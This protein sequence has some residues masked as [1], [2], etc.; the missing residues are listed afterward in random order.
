MTFLPTDLTDGLSD[1]IEANL[2][3]LLDDE[4]VKMWADCEENDIG[5][6]ALAIKSKVEAAIRGVLFDGDVLDVNAS[7]VDFLQGGT[8]LNKLEAAATHWVA[9]NSRAKEKPERIQGK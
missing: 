1:Q 5:H 8:R 7:A 3:A 4:Q 6:I 2:I 9:V